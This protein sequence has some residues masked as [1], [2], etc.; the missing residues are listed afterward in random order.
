MIGIGI[1]RYGKYL[2][3]SA[4]KKSAINGIGR[5]EKKVISRPLGTSINH[6]DQG[7]RGGS[8]NNHVNPQGGGGVSSTV[9]MCYCGP[10]L[11]KII[12]NTR[13][14]GINKSRKTLVL[15][16]QIYGRFG[17]KNSNR[18]TPIFLI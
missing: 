18:K 15:N 5:Y 1:D 6:V 16:C 14:F 13:Q 11:M 8:P 7:G 9:H 3:V 2:S 12:V 10:K 17:F 4:D